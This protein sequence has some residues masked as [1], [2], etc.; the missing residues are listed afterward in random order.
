MRRICWITFSE[1]EKRGNEFYSPIA[2]TRYRVLIP[3]RWLATRGYAQTIVSAEDPDAAMAAA[4]N[5]DVVIFSKSNQ[6][7][8]E[9]ILAEAQRAGAKVIVDLC[10]H[11]FESE[12]DGKHYRE[13]TERA[14]SLVA[15]T[16]EMAAAIRA[17]TNRESVVIG[18]PYEGPKGEPEW[19]WQPGRRIEAVW[20]GHPSNLDTL[21]ALLQ[22][23]S[24]RR[25]DVALSIRICT[26]A[27]AESAE[28]CRRFNRQYGNRIK[29]FFVPW[30]VEQ[31]WQE[32]N[33]TDLVLLPSRV[34]ME[35]K[36]VKSPN[37]LVESVW[38]GRFAL[39]SPLPAYQPFAEWIC[40]GE[41]FC[42][43]LDWLLSHQSE[44]VPLIRAAQ[45]YVAA[46]YSPEVIGKQWEAVIET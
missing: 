25:S 8:N 21:K 24:T 40:L 31:V 4:M 46:H 32:L 30:S 44:I 29:A 7:S 45:D 17:K 16:I 43:G 3:S 9:K 5:A 18:D 38:A 37:R 42:A 10:D 6:I 28:D 14:D 11:K 35:Q 39:A 26:H 20:F 22:Q 36:D 19:N 33:K 2:S 13:M 1:L 41:N 34:G 27:A 15:N 23:L 12:V